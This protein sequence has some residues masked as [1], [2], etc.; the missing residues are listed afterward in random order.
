VPDPPPAWLAGLIP[1]WASCPEPARR[2]LS[3]AR[4]DPLQRQIVGVTDQVTTLLH[5]RYAYL[6]TPL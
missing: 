6:L 2:W 1:D 3:S 4:Y 5:Q